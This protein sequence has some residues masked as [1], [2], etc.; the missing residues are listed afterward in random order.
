MG[1]LNPHNNINIEVTYIASPPN[2]HNR[3]EVVF[4]F[5][6]SSRINVYCAATL[7]LPVLLTHPCDQK[8]CPRACF[9][10]SSALLGTSTHRRWW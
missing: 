10:G 2:D 9:W 7:A 5:G 6:Y 1:C 8:G 3:S 4:S